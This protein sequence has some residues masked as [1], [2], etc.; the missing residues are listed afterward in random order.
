[1]VINLAKE[2]KDLYSGKCKSLKKKNQ[3]R[4]QK[5]ESSLLL[6]NWQNQCCE[7][8]STTVSSLRVQLNPHQSFNDILCRNRKINPKV[9]L[10]AQKTLNSQSSPEQKEQHRDSQY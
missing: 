2:V 1:M 9:H 7:N 5:M 6:F 8:G 10:E 3:V 4:C